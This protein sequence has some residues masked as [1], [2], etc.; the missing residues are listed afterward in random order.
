MSR[1]A[2]RGYRN[3]SRRNQ[4]HPLKKSFLEFTFLTSNVEAKFF[5]LFAKIF[6]WDVRI[7]RK[8]GSEQ[9]L[10][11]N[12]SLGKIFHLFPRITEKSSLF[13]GNFSVWFSKLPQS[14]AKETS[15]SRVILLEKKPYLFRTVSEKLW[16]LWRSFPG[17][18]VKLLSIC[19]VAH[20]KKNYADEFKNFPQCRTW[21]RNTSA[22]A[23]TVWRGFKTDFACQEGRFGDIFSSENDNFFN[24]FCPLRGK[25]WIFWQKFG[26]FFLI[27]AFYRGRFQ[28]IF[29]Q[30]RFFFFIFWQS[31]KISMAKP[32]RKNFENC[33]FDS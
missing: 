4:R 14:M 2:R 19:P 6:L 33:T 13:S 25:I 22:L 27:S 24:H 18:V 16:A 15:W 9:D 8:Q 17:R 7:C 32:F 3:C 20:S 28:A 12:V 21:S 23:N 31:A 5:G 26:A 1:K 29:F 11:Q 30:K 10:K